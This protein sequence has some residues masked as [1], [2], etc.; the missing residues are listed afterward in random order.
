MEF[1]ATFLWR[2]YDLN[3]HT[4]S[5]NWEIKV[6]QSRGK[7]GERIH[8]IVSHC[9]WISAPFIVYLK[10]L[11]LWANKIFIS[12]ILNQIHFNLESRVWGT[13]KKKRL[14]S[15]S[16]TNAIN[17]KRQWEIK[18]K[19]V[20]YRLTCTFSLVMHLLFKKYCHFDFNPW[21]QAAT[22]KLVELPS[23]E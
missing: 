11:S 17:H 13:G 4:L 5:N 2:N 6:A 22:H 12:A 16:M 20:S 23:E 3:F 18:F 21:Q 15:L 8:H 19:K 1:L 14:P 9:E 10:R 7:I